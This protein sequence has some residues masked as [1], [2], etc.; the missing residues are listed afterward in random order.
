[1][2][3]YHLQ[4]FYNENLWKVSAMLLRGLFQ[5]LSLSLHATAYKKYLLAYLCFSQ[6]SYHCHGNAMTA[7]TGIGVCVCGGVCVC[8][9]VV[10]GV[11]ID[12][13]QLQ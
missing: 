10:D 13:C 3:A 5:P 2:H 7:A 11:A 8:V 12:Q 6:G 4:R 1:M 9:C